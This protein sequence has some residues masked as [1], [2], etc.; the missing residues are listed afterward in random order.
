MNDDPNEKNKPV[1][2]PGALVDPDEPGRGGADADAQASVKKAIAEAGQREHAPATVIEIAEAA[3]R[4]RLIFEIRTMRRMKTNIAVQQFV[5]GAKY[6][7]I[8]WLL[9]KGLKLLWGPKG[10]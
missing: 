2:L 5:D 9:W 6:A 8:G 7:G 4:R 10:K 1:P 3:E